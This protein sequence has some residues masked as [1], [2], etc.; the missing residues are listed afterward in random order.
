MDTLGGAANWMPTSA[1]V[2]RARAA[3]RASTASTDTHARVRSD[4]RV[5]RAA[6][7]YR[8]HAGA[9]RASTEGRVA[10]P[11]SLTRV[12]ARVGTAVGIVNYCSTRVS[13]VPA[14]TVPLAPTSR[15]RTIARAQ[16]DTVVR[17]ANISL[18]FAL[19]RRA[20]TTPPVGT[21][22]SA[23]CARAVTT[24]PVDTAI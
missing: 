18:A 17:D 13:A 3:A 8:R 19:V 2:R 5:Q 21:S 11:D 14:R 12:N 20:P 10:P 22:M 23:T 7:T 15:V 4:T 9:V 24:T 6:T 16:P 1:P